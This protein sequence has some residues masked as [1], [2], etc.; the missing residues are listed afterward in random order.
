M[1]IRRYGPTS[2]AGV[3]VTEQEG[4]KPIQA[5]ALGWAGYSGILEKGP[6]GK[7]ITCPSKKSFLKQC[8]SYIP[9][10]LLPDAAIDF[11]DG[12]RGAGGLFL[13]RVTD[14]NEVQSQT[15][16]YTRKTTRAAMGTLKAKNGGR[17]GGKATKYTNDAAADTDITETQLTTGITM[18]TDQYKGGTVVL[19]AVSN[20][21]YPI[22][23]NTSAGVIIVASDQTMKSD[24]TAASDPTNLRYYLELVNGGKALSYE[25]RDGEE[26][27]TTEF[28]LFIYVDGV[29]TL[30]YP[31]LSTDP[32]SGRYWVNKINNDGG[33]NEIVAVDSWTGS[34]VAS[35]RPANHYGV[36]ATVTETVLTAD[37][38]EFKHTVGDA[39][40][41]VT[42]GTTTD[43]M[44]EQVITITM[45]D[46]SD[47]E[48]VSDKF[49]SL[50]TVTESSAFTPNNSWSPPFTITNGATVLEAGDVMVL[51]YKP[52][53]ADQL[54]G[55][56]VYPDKPNAPRE[57]Y[58]IAD[59][60]HKT[61]TA[62]AGSDLTASG[63]TSDEFMIIAAQE[64]A[65]GVDGIAD[66][67]D[68]DYN[69]QAWDI[70]SS[71]FNQMATQGVGLVKMAT[72]GVTA[73]SVQKAGVVYAESKN[74]QYRYEVPKTTIT[75]ADVDAYVNDTLGRND[76]AVVS[77]PSYGNVAD[78]EATT[79]GKL[80]SVTLTGQIHGREARIAADYD[81]Y[82]KAQA[83]TEAILP[84]VLSIPTDDVMLDEEYLNPK[85]INI[86]KKS[87]G[88]YILWGDRTLSVDPNWKWKHQREQMSHYIHSLQQSF[89]WIVFQINDTITQEMAATSLKVFF[90]PE[91]NPKRA[92]RGTTFE[93]AAIIK[94]DDEINTDTTRATGDMF[95]EISLRLADT[96]ERFNILIGKAGIFENVA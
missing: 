90:L 33:N 49:G 3:S 71:P 8:G 9:D 63:A 10:S 40:A 56:F 74:L 57:R 93:D 69:Q 89:D 55:G 2:G 94:V 82:H 28:G 68:S 27:P 96:V 6:V 29:L 20:K 21:S 48:A 79:E 84:K 1:A 16:L 52:F 53:V 46:A 22:I 61:V 86:I 70:A 54:I 58:A 23:S 51:T 65:G 64:M 12:A 75:E 62:V 95:A 14:G 59:N 92:I 37:I 88:N 60:D 80:K 45:T 78:P 34:H 11:F 85:G 18:K 77:F 32:T 76:F 50:G 91:W 83:G 5:A 7:L 42:L 4:D 72:P 35:V 31:N 39:N 30:S 19:D 17:W 24:W 43:A 26:K 44:V 15:T 41:T 36:I 81:G 13:V 67:V 38:H 73:T 25:I 47:G 87:K 66:L